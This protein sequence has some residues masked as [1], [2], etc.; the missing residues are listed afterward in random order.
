M[1]WNGA[2][3]FALS[4]LAVGT[5]LARRVDRSD[6]R[7]LAALAGVLAGLALLFRPDLVVAVGLGFGVLWWQ[8]SRSRRAPLALGAAGALALYVPHLVLAGP[9]AAFEGMVIQPVFDLR[10][11][12]SLPLPPSFGHLDGYLQRAGGVR[13]V[14]WPFSTD[15]IAPQVALWFL[16]VLA[17]SAV[18]VVGGWWCRRR[19]S[20]RASTL[21]PMA[22]FGAA[23]VTQAVQRPDTAHLSWVTGVT[24]PFLIA[25]VAE[26]LSVVH[27]PAG[28]RRRSW[29][30]VAPTAAILLVVI[31][32]YP[33]RTY[34]DLTSQTFGYHAF[35]FPIRHGDRVFYYGDAKLADEAQ[36][37]VDRLARD[38]R[39]GERLVVGP[40]DLS[41]T[42]YSDAFFYYLFPDLVP[43]TRYIEMDPGIADA[44]GSGLATEL[45]HS[46]WLIQSNVWSAWDEPNDSVVAGS[47]APNRVV[48]D[49]YC[50]VLDAGSFRLLRRC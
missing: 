4:G 40:F 44:P 31:P 47:Q 18:L 1:A 20:R 9:R 17:V 37:V 27:R 22:L 35:G 21:W 10:G 12:R 2:L 13:V 32:F 29:V 6:A 3:A 28:A 8:S 41:K 7:G 11:G 25:V 34:L 39:P 49:G 14:L 36:Q 48:R 16:L 15:L 30:A 50:R 46:D 38:S 43:G 23:L 33:L 24:F 45:R 19:G 5:H 26:I 42:P